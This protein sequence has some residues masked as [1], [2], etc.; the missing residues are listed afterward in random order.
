ML[1]AST[2]YV[3]ANIYRGHR[4]IIDK[5]LT[6]LDLLN[7]YDANFISRSR[8]HIV[9]VTGHKNNMFL[10]FL[11]TILNSYDLN[12]IVKVV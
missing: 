10:D 12:N 9:T 11:N 4:N 6:T 8:H 2:K 5:I 3:N 1:L 7:H